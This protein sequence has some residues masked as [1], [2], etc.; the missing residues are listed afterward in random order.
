MASQPSHRRPQ[1]SSDPSCSRPFSCS[2]PSYSWPLVPLA[3]SWKQQLS[4][5]RRSSVI[6]PAPLGSHGVFRLFHWWMLRTVLVFRFLPSLRIHRCSEAAVARPVLMSLW[7]VLNL[8]CSCLV[9]K[10]CNCS[11]WKWHSW[12]RA[13]SGEALN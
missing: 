2:R 8:L 12:L 10:W 9:V 4:E 13:V 5:G 1:G 3:R 7:V 11:F 6:L